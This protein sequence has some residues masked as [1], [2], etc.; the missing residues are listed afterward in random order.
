MKPF[1]AAVLTP[2]VIDPDVRA[3]GVALN[4]AAGAGRLTPGES[5]DATLTGIG[6][7]VAPA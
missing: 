5:N 2:E 6:T 3:R 7:S 4:S 1:A